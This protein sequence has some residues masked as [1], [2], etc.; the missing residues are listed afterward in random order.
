VAAENIQKVINNM[1]VKMRHQ[2]QP[3]CQCIEAMNNFMTIAAHNN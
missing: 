1:A 2:H 3:G